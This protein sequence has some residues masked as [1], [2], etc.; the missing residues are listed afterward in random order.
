M[1]NANTTPRLKSLKRSGS[2]REMNPEGMENG[3]GPEMGDEN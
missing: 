3:D 2:A 1:Q